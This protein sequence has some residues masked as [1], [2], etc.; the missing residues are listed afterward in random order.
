[1]RCVQGK[2]NRQPKLPERTPAPKPSLAPKTEPRTQAQSIA[3]RRPRRQ[4]AASASIVSCSECRVTG[5]TSKASMPLLL[6]ASI[7]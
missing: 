5:T 1:M 7:D 6:Q 2:F 4:P 3:R